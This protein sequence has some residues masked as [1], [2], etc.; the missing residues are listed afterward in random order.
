MHRQFFGS[1]FQ[2]PEF[3]EIFVNDINNTFDFA[4]RKFVLEKIS[5]KN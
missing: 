1:I 2:N 3:V 5:E 4:C